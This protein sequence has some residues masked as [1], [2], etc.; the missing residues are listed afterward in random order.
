MPIE[1]RNVRANEMEEI[2]RCDTEMWVG[3]GEAWQ[4]VWWDQEGMYGARLKIFPKG[5]F[6]AYKDGR[7]VGF[8]TSLI[9]NY[10]P[11]EKKLGSWNE[12]TGDGY[13]KTHNPSGNALYVASLAISKH[14]RGQGIG[15]LLCEAQKRLTV[16]LGL[17]YLVLGARIPGFRTYKEKNPGGTP[18]D[19]LRQKNE[20]NEPLDPEVRFYAR[21]GLLVDYVIPDYEEDRDSMNYGVVMFWPNPGRVK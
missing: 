4:E 1:I 9:I 12:I 16:E 11:G 7:L 18:E 3:E 2:K 20:K 17:D 14:S 19:Y 15:T 21:N 5:F 6:G 10:N 8:T 13:F